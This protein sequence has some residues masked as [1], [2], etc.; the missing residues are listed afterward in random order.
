MILKEEIDLKSKELNIST[1]N[2]QRDYLFGWLLFYIFTKS[3][4]KDEIFLKGG[5]ALRKGYFVNTRFSG[6]LDFGTPNDIQIDTLKQEINNALAY[7]SEQSGIVFVYDQNKFQE[8]FQE[9]NETR[10][11]VVEVKI[12]FKDFYGKT[13]HIIL[14]ISLDITKFDKPYLDIQNK[15]LLHPY[16]DANLVECEIKCSQLEEILATKL[17]CLL[18]RERPTDLFDYIYSLYLNKELEINRSEV[19]SVFL[20]KTIFHKNPTIAKNILLKLPFEYIKA[21]WAK[22]IVCSKESWI[23]IE[24]AISFFS[25]NITELF[26]D[27]PDQSYQDRHFF[28]PEMR[29][30]IFKAG[31]DQTL[32]KIIYD[33]EERLVEPYSLKF[34]QKKDG[35]ENEYLNAF[36]ISGGTSAPGIKKFLPFKMELTEN[37]DTKFSPQYEI[38]L[39]KAGE[40]PDNKLLYDPYKQK[41]TKARTSKSIYEVQ[42]PKRAKN[43]GPSN[44]YKCSNCGKRF[45]RKSQDGQLKPHKSRNGSYCYGYGLYQGIKY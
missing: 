36:K 10:W 38:E 33:G 9:Y 8:K 40:Y 32:L 16:S 14:K 5:N 22:T 41:A 45:I 28:P 21:L 34:Q 18:Q 1:A 17:K 11:E 6:D 30:A 31:R 15:P 13:D 43:Y 7:I 4:L 19:L 37:T 27:Y 44:I 26:S 2:I 29:N 3:S 24:D 12:Y 20:K 42:K 35:E 39:C 23:E 25:T